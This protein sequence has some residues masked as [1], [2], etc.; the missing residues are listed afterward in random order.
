MLRR[1]ESENRE[2]NREE[3]QWTSISPRELIDQFIIREL[4][5]VIFVRLVGE[6]VRLWESIESHPMARDFIGR[7]GCD[8]WCSSVGSSFTGNSYF[9]RVQETDFHLLWNVCTFRRRQFELDSQWMHSSLNQSQTLDFKIFQILL[10]FYIIFDFILLK[11]VL[12]SLSYMFHHSMECL[13][14]CIF[15]W[16][17]SL[18]KV[19]FC[20]EAHQWLGSW[21]VHLT[22]NTFVSI[23]PQAKW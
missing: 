5:T 11:L 18:G 13:I 12:F 8:E 6:N 15:I 1:G 16:F 23:S 4:S 20:L 9:L 2:A 19:A 17:F 21:F 22:W 14:L 7:L 3:K 10:N